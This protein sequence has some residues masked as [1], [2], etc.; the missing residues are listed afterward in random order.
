LPAPP[1]TRTWGDTEDGEVR[2]TS[3]SLDSVLTVNTPLTP[4]ESDENGL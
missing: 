1:T 2:D 4:S 3:L